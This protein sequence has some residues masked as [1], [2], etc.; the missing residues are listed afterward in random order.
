MLVFDN[1]LEEA[2]ELLQLPLHVGV[3]QGL[4]A[5]AAAPQHIAFAA[6]GLR[7]IHRGLH[8]GRGIGE[9][10]RIGIGCGSCHVT[11]MRE[12]IGGPPE[13]T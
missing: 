4:V 8:L 6:Q 9:N 13:K 2:A 1:E 12:K 7:D 10:L 11:A 3:E 5:F